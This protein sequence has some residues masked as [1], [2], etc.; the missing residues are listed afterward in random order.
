LLFLDDTHYWWNDMPEP[1]HFVIAPNT[2]H[3]FITGIFEAVPTISAYLNAHLN[4]HTVPEF[5]WTISETTGE[6]VATLNNDGSVVHDAHVWYAYSCGN[7]AFDNGMK[8]RDWRVAHLDNPCSCGPFAEG[9]C[10]NLKSVWNK[11]KL[12]MTT[13]KGKR[14]FSAKFDAPEDG[15]YI[16]FFIDLKFHNP[17]I[18]IPDINGKDLDALYHPKPETPAGKISLA[19]ERYFEWGGF[20]KDFGHFFEFTT[21]V[22]IWPNTFPYADCQGTACGDCPMV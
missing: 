17:D 20:P 6:I 11:Q 7:N 16:A 4:K 8:R 21:E 2:E 19:Y 18:V 22:S 15:R 3:S 13:V 5:T 12:E 10:A 14:T 9:Y 1:K